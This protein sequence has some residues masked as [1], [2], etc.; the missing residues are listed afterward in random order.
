MRR[1]GGRGGLELNQH[2]G[3]FTAVVRNAEA[4][5]VF[6]DFRMRENN[7]IH[8]L[9]PQIHAANLQHRVVARDGTGLNA[10]EG[11]A[12]C[13]LS[14]RFEDNLVTRPKAQDRHRFASKRGQDDL[15]LLVFARRLPGLRVQHFGPHLVLG[16]MH[17]AAST[18]CK[19][20]TML[21]RAGNAAAALCRRVGVDQL[22]T[23]ER[24][25]FARP[26]HIETKTAQLDRL[27]CG[28]VAPRVDSHLAADCCEPSQINRPRGEEVGRKAPHHLE[29]RFAFHVADRKGTQPIALE[30]GEQGDRPRRHA[31]RHHVVSNVTRHHPRPVQRGC[32]ARQRFGDIRTCVG[33]DFLPLARGAAGQKAVLEQR[34]GH[35]NRRAERRMLTLIG[36]NVE[37]VDHRHA[38]AEVFRRPDI[39]RRHTCALHPLA[40]KRTGSVGALQGRTQP[41]PAQRFQLGTRHPFNNR[42]EDSLFHVFPHLCRSIGE[43]TIGQS[44]SDPWV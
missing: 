28:K 36:E 11:S 29:P 18:V 2:S 15:T 22:R 9:R 24:F 13:A 35:R 14:V 1:T 8:R 17:H 38:V 26:W 33:V 42:I 16:K 25:H 3:N 30:T 20:R 4:T 12:A 31:N 7:R 21:A 37:L 40:V 5:V 10:V 32:P 19:I 43:T 23:P 27:Q 39:V 41:P 44:S 34:I 6:V